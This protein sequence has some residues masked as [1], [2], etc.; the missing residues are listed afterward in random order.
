M[1]LELSEVLEIKTVISDP[2]GEFEKVL[3]NPTDEDFC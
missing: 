2:D 3:L 1:L